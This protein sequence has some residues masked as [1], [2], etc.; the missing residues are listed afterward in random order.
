MPLLVAA[1]PIGNA[2]DASPRLRDAL[3]TADVIAAEDTRR[4]RRLADRARDRAEPAGSSATTTRTSRR[5]SARCST[6]CAR[7]RPCCSS[8][9]PARRWCPTPATGWSPR[10]PRKGCR[11][12]SVPGPSAVTRRA[13]RVRPARRTGGASRASCRARPESAAGCSPSSRPSGARWSSSRRRTGSAAA[14]ADLA[15]AFGADRRAAVCRELTKTYEEVRR[16]TLGG[17]ADWAARRR[18]RARSRWSS[19]GAPTVSAQLGRRRD[20]RR[21]GGGATS[22]AGLDPPRRGRRRRRP[23]AGLSRRVVYDAVT[24]L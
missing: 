21:G 9:T 1:T 19:A 16:D 7:A 14:L 11:S 6:S 12:A 13:R 2:D 24:S 18:A 22:T 8:P 10:R 23:S 20:A 3:A 4:L 15:A 5:G 17:L